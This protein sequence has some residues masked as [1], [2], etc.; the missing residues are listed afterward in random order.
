MDEALDFQETID[1]WL[2]VVYSNQYRLMSRL[3]PQA[4][5]PLTIE[6]LREGPLGQD[7][8]RLA[9]LARG[10]VR[11]AKERVLEAIDSVLQILFWPPA[12]EDYTVP[13]S[14]WET[15][16]GR[17][18]SMAKFRAYEPTELVSIGSAAQQLGVTRPTI[19][20]WM[21]D[22]TLGYVRDEMSGRTFVV[23]ADVENLRRSM[24]T[25]GSEA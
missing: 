2:R 14:F 12:A 5:Q 22:R 24:E 6:Q 7:L 4:I 21:D 18:I 9:A 13:R 25:M 16:L 10:E 23:R 3:Y 15:D 11:E 20:R 17:M 8:A 1:K 19:Y